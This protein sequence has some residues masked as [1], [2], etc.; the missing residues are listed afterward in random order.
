VGIPE[1]RHSILVW[2]SH[3][4]FVAENF[5]SDEIALPQQLMIDPRQVK[6]TFG[7]HSCEVDP[8][9]RKLMLVGV[10]DRVLCAK[11]QLHL[12]AAPPGT[13][14]SLRVSCACVDEENSRMMEKLFRLS[15][16]G[17]ISLA[18]QT[19]MKVNKTKFGDKVV[20]ACVAGIDSGVCDDAV[21]V[22]HG[23]AALIVDALKVASTEMCSLAK[24]VI[25]TDKTISTLQLAWLVRYHILDEL[26]DSAVMESII[27]QLPQRPHPNPPPHLLAACAPTSPP[28]PAHHHAKTAHPPAQGQTQIPSNVK[29]KFSLCGVTIWAGEMNFLQALS[30]FNCDSVVNSVNPQLMNGA[31]MARA[32]SEYAGQAYEQACRAYLQ[33]LPFKALAIGSAYHFPPFNIQSKGLKHIL[34]TVIPRNDKHT[35]TDA[36]RRDFSQAINSA[37]SVASSHGSV[38]VALPGMG[39]GVYGWSPDEATELTVRAVRQWLIA[40]STTTSVKTIV[41]LDISGHVTAAYTRAMANITPNLLA[42][43]P[44]SVS[45]GASAAPPLP[46]T[47]PVL[48]ANQWYWHAQTDDIPGKRPIELGGEIHFFVPYGYDQLVQIEEAFQ[49]GEKAVTIVNPGNGWRYT[50]YFDRLVQINSVNGGQRRILQRPMDPKQP[51]PQYAERLAAYDAVHGPVTP[52]GIGAPVDHGPANLATLALDQADIVEYAFDYTTG[53]AIMGADW[54][55]ENVSELLDEAVK[56]AT[57][58]M[59]IPIEILRALLSNNPAITYDHCLGTIRNALSGLGV[60][61]EKVE[62]EDWMVLITA[63]GIDALNAAEKILEQVK[64]DIYCSHY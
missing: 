62:S 1:F 48:P 63:I 22:L 5:C 45:G 55:I 28:A 56:E 7:L 64:A 13:L 57:I 26:S 11:A 10:K 29:G 38:G 6:S 16:D 25:K 40:N 21:I 2:R 46:A 41:L 9:S 36:M 14:V 39:T 17:D 43:T 47:R 27:P 15:V 35:P 23:H 8:A 50:L 49:R 52:A 58:S 53:L 59:Q 33:N 60:T 32:V 19:C 37:L 18:E 34:N 24:K 61:V 31:G 20:S 30:D 51:P 4:A 44:L 54:K 12:M 42:A 3:L